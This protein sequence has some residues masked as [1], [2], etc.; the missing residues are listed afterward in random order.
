MDTTNFKFFANPSPGR[1]N[2]DAREG[3]APTPEFSH[4]GGTFADAISLTL[5][6]PE[7]DAEI[8][9]TT[10]SALPTR[11]SPLYEQPIDVNHLFGGRSVPCATEDGN[12]RLLDINGDGQL[13]L[14]DAVYEL[15]FL[16][17]GGAPPALGRDCV[18]IAACPDACAGGG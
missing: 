13:G 5:T 16:F 11:A 6:S 17:Q 9:H 15:G 4:D 7:P 18:P 12:L 14:T 10:N 8:R 3:V 1:P 2:A